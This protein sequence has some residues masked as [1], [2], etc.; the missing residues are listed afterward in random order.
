MTDTSVIEL[1]IKLKDALSGPSQKAGQEISKLGQAMDKFEQRARHFKSI[2]YAGAAMEGMAWGLG[3]ALKHLAEP[4]IRFQEAQENLERAT[5]MSTA[6]LAQFQ[7]QA[8]A[9]SEKLPQSAE[10]ITNAQADLAR[11]L[12]S[13]AR[14]MQTIG[15]TAEFATA[16][17]LDMATS[18]QL[19]AS[20]YENLGDKSVPV[21]TGFTQIADL[22]TIL[23]NRFSTSTKNGQMMVRSFARMSGA[24]QMTGVPLKQAAAAFAVLNQS[25]LGGGR[26]AGEYLGQMLTSLG[27]LDKDGIPTLEKYG[28][29]LSGSVGK[30]GNFHMDLMKTLGNMQRA[31]PARLEAYLKSLGGEGSMLELLLH[32]YGAM[33]HAMHVLSHTQGATAT[34]AEEMNKTWA[35]QLIDLHNTYSNVERSIG[36]VLV[37]LLIQV[38]HWLEPILDRIRMFAEAHPIL[39]KLALVIMLVGTA[40]LAL[41]GFVAIAIS[42]FGG[43]AATVEF[44][45]T[46]L[47]GFEGVM[48]ALDAVMAANP[49]GALILLCAALAF[50]LYELLTHWRAVGNYIMGWLDP[51]FPPMVRAWN[52]IQAFGHRV[53]H[54]GLEI[55]N[56]FGSHPI[57]ASLMGPIGWLLMM[58]DEIMKH[59]K[60]IE[61]FFEHI[62]GVIAAVFK[63]I[64]HFLHFGHAA[65]PGSASVKHHQV[66]EHVAR[67]MRAAPAAVAGLSLAAAPIAAAHS[68]AVN[69]GIHFHVHVEAGAGTNA[70]TIADQLEDVL[71][72]D[73]GRFARPVA[74][75]MDRANG[76]WNSTGF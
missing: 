50:G 60:G 46:V 6:Q 13:S 35:Q 72:A 4:A 8:I 20:A 22:M 55:L 63:D 18:S 1:L 71:N 38:A 19:L 40:L 36:L 65:T 37:P 67:A 16:T 62:G 44:A 75:I 12:G 42:A 70:E 61:L 21:K 2:F 48:V 45:G 30:H 32:K 9:L 10:T 54:W 51:L 14:A 74:N 33:E 24:V 66:I 68:S 69:G 73:P 58:S 34:L 3:E 39:T 17:G 56:W 31:N 7:D 29:M 23:Q 52:A 47:E 5:G 57:F 53:L 25:G 26:G 27:K 11:M 15:I 28:I 76:Q 59:W 64:E 49:I 43:L 41:G